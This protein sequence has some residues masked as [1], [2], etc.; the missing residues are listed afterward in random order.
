MLSIILVIVRCVCVYVCVCVCVC[1]YV[2]VY[3]CVCVCV[4]VY[5]CVLFTFL[6]IPYFH[7]LSLP[8]F[9]PL[10]SLTTTFEGGRSKEG[11][12]WGGT[13]GHEGETET[14]GGKEEEGSGKLNGRKA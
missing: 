13:V 11:R 12:G 8:I 9:L 14:D 6:T 3:V 5:V 1:V 2:Y 10:L 4:C 7:L